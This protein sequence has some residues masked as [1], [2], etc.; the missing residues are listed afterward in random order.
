MI[1]PAQPAQPLP[2]LN[3]LGW[4]R[5]NPQNSAPFGTP[6]LTFLTFFYM[7]ERKEQAHRMRVC[8]LIMLKLVGQVR[9][10]TLK[11]AEIS[12]KTLPNLPL[13]RLGRGW[14]MPNL[15]DSQ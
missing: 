3:G 15:G 8:S 2:N 5:S 6:C 10:T 11:P 13:K 9:H 12:H 4:A 1:R 14:A 7:K